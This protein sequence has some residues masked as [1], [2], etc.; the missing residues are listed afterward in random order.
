MKELCMISSRLLLLTGG[1]FAMMTS[2]EGCNGVTATQVATD[3]TNVLTGIEAAV[4]A[5]CPEVAPFISIAAAATA[6]PAAAN[7][8]KYASAVC[9]PQGTMITG[10]TPSASTAAWIGQLSAELATLK[11][12]AAAT[13][14]Q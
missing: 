13:P 12:A 8:I 4:N 14:A 6:G 2:L 5:A 7:I 10:F 9:T 11:P 1:L 3:A